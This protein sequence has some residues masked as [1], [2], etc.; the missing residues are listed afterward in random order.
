MKMQY[1]L[2][3]LSVLAS[4]V[5]LGLINVRKKEVVK[6]QKNT[7]FQSTKLRVTYDVQGEYRHELIRAQNLLDKTKALVNNLGSELSQIQAKEVQQKNDLEACLGQ[8]KQATDNMGSVE[9]EISNAKNEFEK[10]KVTWAAQVTSLRQ[11]AEQRSK[12]CDFVKKESVEGRNMCGDEP[13]KKEAAPKPEVPKP[14][15]PKPEVPKPEVPLPDAAKQDAAKQDAAKQDAAKQDA[16]KQ[17]APKQDAP[18]QD[19]MPAGPKTK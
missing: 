1:V 7:S 11:Q 6:E 5:L 18:K 4:V 15:V 9:E 13:P 3:G 14:E 2:V 8:K 19:S 16:A 12:V 17:D 10:Q